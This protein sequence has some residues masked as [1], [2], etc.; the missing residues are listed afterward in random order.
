MTAA[1]DFSTPHLIRNEAEYDAVVAEI[2]RL[3]DENPPEGS[4]S[5]ERIEFLSL[6]IEDYDHKHHE[7][8][9]GH[10]SPQQVVQFMLDQRGMK[11]ADLADVM[12]GRARV[13]QF[14][15]GKRLLSMGQVLKLRALLDVPAD[16]LVARPD[17]R[18]AKRRRGSRARAT[19]A[20]RK[21]K[22]TLRSRL[23]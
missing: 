15:S 12:G 23:G 8:P 7:L 6:L 4:P 10:V 11:R 20:G 3:L 5:E 17:M 2:D 19:S 22:R 21:R 13:S 14:F 1:L 16:L 9:G 18:E